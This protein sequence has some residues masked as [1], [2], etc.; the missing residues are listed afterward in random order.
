MNLGNDKTFSYICFEKVTSKKIPESSPPGWTSV[1]AKE[2][3]FL[4]FGATKT[5]QHGW[6]V[7]M[8]SYTQG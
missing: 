1:D 8:V 7:L 4:G 2:Y 6:H 5:V 3:G